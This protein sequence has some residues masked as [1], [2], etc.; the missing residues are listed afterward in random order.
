MS[1]VQILL[2][3][4]RILGE[5]YFRSPDTVSLIREFHHEYQVAGEFV[6]QYTGQDAAEEA[7]DL[8]NNPCREQ[9]REEVYGRLRSVSV[10]D[11]VRVDNKE[12]VCMSQGWKLLELGA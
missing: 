3:P 10:G 9:E 12:W 7:F 8:T 4:S 1:K 11:I 2:A 5:F 6:T